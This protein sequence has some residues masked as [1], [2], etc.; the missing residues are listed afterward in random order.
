[1][2]ATPLN[3]A[4]TKIKAGSIGYLWAGLAIPAVGARLTLAA[5]AD[6][7]MTPDATANPNA[8]HLGLTRAG[9]TAKIIPAYS[10]YKADEYASDIKKTM[11]G[12]AS[13]IE[14]ELLQTLDISILKLL[15]SGFGTYASGTGY[16]ELAIGIGAQT[17]TS[18]A[19]IFPTEADPSKYCVVHLYKAFNSM[20]LDALGSARKDMAGLKVKFEALDIPSRSGGD[21][22]G[23]FFIQS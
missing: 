3:F 7:I 9:A 22:Q 2:P 18:L 5:N 20:G 16:D 23:K 13:T 21:T 14:A 6:G 4:P 8:L 15:S 17:Y 1:M 12:L 11:D 10:G 19:L